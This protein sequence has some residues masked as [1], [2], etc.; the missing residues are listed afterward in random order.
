[1]KLKWDDKWRAVVG[2][3]EWLSGEYRLLKRVHRQEPSIAELRA[4]AHAVID[5]AL[6]WLVEE[7]LTSWSPITNPD[8]S[9]ARRLAFVARRS[10]NDAD[11]AGA[12]PQWIMG[13]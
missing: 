10:F 6:Q 7:L 13:P 9:P 12:R 4:Q 1:M 2:V 11:L 5:E 8:G 3:T